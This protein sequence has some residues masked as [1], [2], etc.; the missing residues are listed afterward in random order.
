M[1]SCGWPCSLNTCGRVRRLEGHVLDVD[2]LD[3]ELGRLRGGGGA[4][5]AVG[6]LVFGHVDQLQQG[7]NKGGSPIM[8]PAGMRT[9]GLSRDP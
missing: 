4:I 9:C 1:L 5:G 6:G 7:W 2:L 3:G 8:A